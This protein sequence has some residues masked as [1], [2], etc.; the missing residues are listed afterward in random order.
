MRYLKFKD[1]FNKYSDEVESQQD[2][3]HKEGQV[4]EKFTEIVDAVGINIMLLRT[5]CDNNNEPINKNVNSQTPIKFPEDSVDFVLE[6]LKKH[7]TYDY[8][9]I[10]R[11]DF[12]DASLDTLDFLLSGFCDYILNLN[13]PLW[14][15]LK[16]KDAME[17]R[18][19]IKWHRSRDLLLKQCVRI[20][21]DA[22]N[23][24]EAL[25]TLNSDDKAEFASFMA[26]SVEQLGNRLSQIY[27]HYIDTR[28]EEIEGIVK[29]ENIDCNNSLDE[30]NKELLLADVLEKDTAYQNLLKER[31][32][33]IAS[34]DFVK[35]KKRMYELVNSKMALLYKKHRTDI[36]GT[37]ELK[38]D[39]V[40]I[41]KRPQEVLVEAINYEDDVERDCDTMRIKEL[42]KSEEQIEEERKAV[43]EL[44]KCI[45]DE[46]R[47]RKKDA[48]EFL[49]KHNM[50]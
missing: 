41:V 1:V 35:N 7:T 21:V 4:R 6:I 37:E 28:Q 23:H 16:E 14:V 20:I 13:Y 11:G 12:D 9:C 39:P 38:E 44:L 49:R 24:Q 29:D 18:L 22:E 48:E 2:G 5:E 45:E 46:R 43:E 33:I 26:H 17:K 31:E 50:K 40:I 47:K 30:F 32:E 15:C 42:E 36:F 34:H 19:R 10:R 8:K 27:N 25:F 3:G